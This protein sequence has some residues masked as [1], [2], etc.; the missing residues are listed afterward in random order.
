MRV[1]AASEVLGATLDCCSKEQLEEEG[2]EFGDEPVSFAHMPPTRAANR[3]PHDR[4][5]KTR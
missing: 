2:F 3:S 1:R 4:T 5:C